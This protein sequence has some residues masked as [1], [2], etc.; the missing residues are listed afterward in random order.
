MLRLGFLHRTSRTLGRDIVEDDRLFVL[1]GAGRVAFLDVRDA[2]AVAARVFL[3]PDRYKGQ[4]LVLTGPEAL[5]FG[6]VAATLTR[7]LGRP[8]RY[9]P[10]TIP[11]YAWHLRRVRQLPWMRAGADR[12]PRGPATRRRRAGGPDR[13]N[14]VGRAPGTPFEYVARAAETWSPRGARTTA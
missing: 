9:E 8:V 7:V 11:G 1:R 13:A 3:E 6:D 10:A 4:H 5:T 14:R 2:A 12:A